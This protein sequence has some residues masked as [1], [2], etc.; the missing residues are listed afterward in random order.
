MCA[1][2]WVYLATLNTAISG[3][4]PGYGARCP[5]FATSNYND[6]T[7]IQVVCLKV[8]LS[9]SRVN[10]RNFRISLSS[11]SSSI[12]LSLYL[13]CALCPFK[14]N[15]DFLLGFY[16]FSCS[17]FAVSVLYLVDCSLAK[18]SYLYSMP[19]LTPKCRLRHNQEISGNERNYGKN[20]CRILL[21]Q[22]TQN[23]SAGY[24]WVP[25]WLRSIYLSFH[26]VAGT[27]QQFILVVF[28]L[29][30]LWLQPQNTHTQIVI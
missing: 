20:F 4:W 17:L 1:K 5:L 23:Y 8:L 13:S 21:R 22:A 2:L 26:L 30:E 28:G 3:K 25:K 19:L 27:W 12:Y 18:Q 7:A 9:F 11:I 10:L 14:I 29:W 24:I 6:D 16:L 15:T